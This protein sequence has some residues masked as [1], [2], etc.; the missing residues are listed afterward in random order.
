[1]DA[2]RASVDALS[3]KMTSGGGATTSESGGGTGGTAT[4]PST[5]T[6]KPP[7][8]NQD[9]QKNLNSM[10]AALKKR[11]MTDPNYIKAVLGNVMKES[12]GKMVN[13]NMD[14]SGTSNDR[15]RSIFG[16]RATSK[17]DEELNAIKKDPT[18]MAEM[19][20]GKDTAIG[21]GMG[22]TEPG[23]GW[24]YRGRG[25]IGITGKAL[26]AQASQALFGDDRPVS[27]T[28]LTLPTK[29]IV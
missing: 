4:G 17:T 20:Y 1:M 5:S 25:F 11:G 12:G 19:M 23:D 21:K 8:V 2:L 15:I 3:G 27:Y 13:E 7:P 22:N 16:Q 24:K 14:Y 10:A 29:R 9:I 6:Y 26:Y 28:H 18:K